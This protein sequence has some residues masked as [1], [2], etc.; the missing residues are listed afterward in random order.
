MSAPACIP[1]RSTHRWGNPQRGANHG[2][3][4]EYCAARKSTEKDQRGRLRTEY[5][6][7]HEVMCHRCRE[8]LTA[9]T[10]EVAARAERDEREAIAA[11]ALAAATALAANEATQRRQWQADP[12]IRRG[13]RERNR[14]LLR[15]SV[16]VRASEENAAFDVRRA[17][18]AVRLREHAIRDLLH[19]LLH[20]LSDRLLW[21]DDYTTFARALAEAG[22]TV[23][24]LAANPVRY[25]IEYHPAPCSILDYPNEVAS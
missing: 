6:E 17:E 9:E 7:G 15:P 4:C 23:A 5:E 14:L 16:L 20:A 12:S 25:V 1:G 11:A 2:W 13:Y 18:V 21:S 22:V 24:Q 19:A 8:H 10:A 3:T